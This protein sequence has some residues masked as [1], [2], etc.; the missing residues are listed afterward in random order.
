MQSSND[1]IQQ[2]KTLIEE[3]KQ[4]LES[5]GDT[6]SDPAAMADAYI[7]EYYS[8]LYKKFDEVAN[9]IDNIRD[10]FGGSNSFIETLLGQLDE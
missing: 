5:T 3:Y 7:S 2:R 8:E 4:L 6:Q 10:K 1:Y 9:Y